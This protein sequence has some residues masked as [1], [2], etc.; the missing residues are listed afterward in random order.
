MAFVTYELWAKNAG[1]ALHI[2]DAAARQLFQ[3]RLVVVSARVPFPL[4]LE[5][6]PAWRP[7]IPRFLLFPSVELLIK[8]R[9][10]TTQEQLSEEESVGKGGGRREE[11]VG[12]EQ[13]C[14][15]LFFK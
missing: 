5:L 14:I 1:H 7:T 10:A 8:H 15:K 2:C 12:E 3:R 11:D 13:P 6:R 4:G 9:K